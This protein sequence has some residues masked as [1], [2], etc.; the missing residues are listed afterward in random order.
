MYNTA[1]ALPSPTPSRLWPSPSLS[2]TLAIKCENYWTWCLFATLY[3]VFSMHS[4]KYFM[5]NYYYFYLIYI[6]LIILLLF[7]CHAGQPYFI[8]VLPTKLPTWMS[9]FALLA[10]TSWI[11]FCFNSKKANGTSCHPIRSLIILLT[12]KIAWRRIKDLPLSGCPIFMLNTCIIM[13]DWIGQLYYHEIT[14]RILHYN[15]YISNIISEHT[16]ILKKSEQYYFT[17]RDRK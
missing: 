4:I 14:T 8:M 6:S 15:S 7:F 17:S 1:C 2:S 16:L 10:K 12:K 3:K 11:I 13:T 5:G 9:Y